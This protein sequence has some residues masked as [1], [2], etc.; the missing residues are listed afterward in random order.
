MLAPIPDPSGTER[1]KI[2]VA[3]A[4]VAQII[5][6]ARWSGAPFAMVTFDDRPKVSLPLA[7]IDAANLPYVE[8][9]IPLLTPSGHSA[10]WDALAMGADLLR[11]PTGAVVGTIVLVTDGW[12]NASTAFAPP[13]EPIPEGGSAR[14]DLFEHLL[15]SGSR[16]DLRILGIGSGE[17]RDQGVDAARMQGLLHG[18][19][20]K[21]VEVGSPTSFVFEEVETAAGLFREMVRAFVDVDEIEPVEEIEPSD[22]P[23]E[24]A[25]AAARALTSPS[26]HSA[27]TRLASPPSEAAAAIAS[28]GFEVGTLPTSSRSAWSLRPK[29]GPLLDVAEAYLARDYGAASEALR[30]S[31]LLIPPVTYLYWQ[32]KIAFGRGDVIDAAGA[33]LKAWNASESLP[34]PSRLKV[35]RRLA[36]LQAQLQDDPETESLLRYIERT[37]L[38]IAEAPADLQARVMDLFERLIALRGSFLT[39]QRDRADGG[40]QSPGRHAEAVQEVANRL[41]DVRRD[42]A[43]D[44]PEVLEA[45]AFVE[46]CLDQLREPEPLR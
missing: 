12:D 37:D 15:P 26:Q 1:S 17:A 33:L 36:L 16:L 5:V 46:I 2:E 44:R 13:S 18:L 29:F 19:S 10:I 35:S 32:A 23:A 38:R 31:E 40:D 24:L 7:P 22:V 8:R 27:I 41:R 30:R 28:E 3:R 43:S 4:A 25:E 14:R 11:Q 6:Q 20:S 9:I 21:A 39:E 42:A 34:K 45:L